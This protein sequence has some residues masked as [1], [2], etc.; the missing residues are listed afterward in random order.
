MKKNLL[1][2]AVILFSATF[3]KAQVT[4]INSNR[5]LYVAAPINN[6]QTILSSE[7]DST[8]WVTE[9]NFE[10]TEQLSTTV[11]YEESGG[12]LNGKFIFSGTA[13]GTGTELY[14]SDGTAAGTTLLKDINTGTGGSAPS[15]FTELN[16]FLYFTAATA[17]EGRELWRTNGTE[18]GTTLVKDIATGT[19]SG[20]TAS[21]FALFSNGSYLL[22][23]AES[24]AAQGMEL[25]KSDGT[26]AGTVILKD[27]HTGADSSM[28]HRFFAYNNLVLFLAKNAA[29]GEELW[30][31]DGTEAG[32]VLIKDINP[33]PAGC[34]SIE[35]F[36]GFGFPVAFYTHQFNNKVF[37]TATDGT[38]A[39]Q[40]WGTDG[41]TA[42]TALLSDIVPGLGIASIPLFDAINVP[43]KFI[44]PVA[45]GIDRSELWQSDGTAAGTSLFKSFTPADPSDIPYIALNFSFQNGNVVQNLFQGNTFFFVGSNTDNGTELWKSDGTLANTV[46]VKDINPGTGNGIDLSGNISYLYTS[47]AFFFAAND[48]TSGNEL[49]KT[50]GTTAG[51][52]MVED[53][54]SGAADADPLLSVVNNNKIMFSATDGDDPLATDFFA[55]DGNFE[56]LPVRLTGFSVNRQ[57]KHAVLQ[58]FT[59]QEINSSKFIVQRSFDGLQFENIGMVQAAGNSNSRIQYQFTDENIAERGVSAVYYRLVAKDAD[60]KSQNSA[61][62]AL[63]LKVSKWNVQLVN[64]PVQQTIRLKVMGAENVTIAIR[65]MSGRLVYNN[66]LPVINNLL[67][68]PGEKLPHGYY[69]IT[70]YSGT[71]KTTLRFIK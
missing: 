47:M 32:T 9:G 20:N 1:T 37:F 48:G 29:N 45:D 19:A 7:F 61:V 12:L 63:K 67:T 59:E 6:V 25:W 30:K 3:T 60:G 38:S 40:V 52:T 33:G 51:T 11:K 31:T 64:N 14:I 18:A 42:N 26:N 70:V 4:L 22:F 36:P 8:L 55:V 46:M 57:N 66:T 24:N 16:G 35:L 28:P 56:P 23:A 43:G 34:T 62:V 13:P 21:G 65:E 44:F 49:W 68:V 71:E 17:A 2:V 27:I 41:T 53:I 10:S 15:G 58:W 54:N 39:G 50:D 69:A 5:N